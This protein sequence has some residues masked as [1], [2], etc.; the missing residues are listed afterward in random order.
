[1]ILA[2]VTIGEGKTEGCPD[3][4]ATRLHRNLASGMAATYSWITDF[5]EVWSQGSPKSRH[6]TP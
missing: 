4:L 2:C 1:M 3:E 6:L 5:C